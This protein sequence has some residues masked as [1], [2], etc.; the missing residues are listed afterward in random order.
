MTDQQNKTKAYQSQKSETKREAML[1]RLDVLAD[2]MIGVG[3]ALALDIELTNRDGY[4][5]VDAT[6][7][8]V[9]DISSS[10]L[11]KALRL[12][13]EAVRQER[14]EARLDTFE[15]VVKYTV[16]IGFI[17][18]TSYYLAKLIQVIL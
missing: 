7:Q 10:E 3:Q 14:I 17:L 15:T 12:E 6:E 16:A 9:I 18:V 4:K 5:T 2:C 1:K 8:K 11:A 13:L